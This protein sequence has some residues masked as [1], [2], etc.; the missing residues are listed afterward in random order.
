MWIEFLLRHRVRTSGKRQRHLC[1]SYIVFIVILS[2]SFLC[3]V[4][5]TNYAD[6]TLFILTN[7]KRIREMTVIITKDPNPF[8][9]H[10][11]HSLSLF[12]TIYFL[13][14]KLIILFW[15]NTDF[16][17]RLPVKHLGER[18]EIKQSKSNPLT[19]NG[20]T[21]LQDWYQ[22]WFC[23]FFVLINWIECVR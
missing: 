3:N 18:Q 22:G 1:S 2:N 23:K 6:A 19:M 17:H 5:Y 7:N 15:V 12:C 11:I 20:L 10:D 4:N 14:Y 13:V 16:I 9:C 21:Y 8:S